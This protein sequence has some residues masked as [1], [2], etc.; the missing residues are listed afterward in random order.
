M[1]TSSS[2]ALQQLPS[3]SRPRLQSSQ[4]LNGAEDTASHSIHGAV[5]MRLPCL[6][7]WVLPMGHGFPHSQIQEK[8]IQGEDT[9]STQDE[10]QSVLPP[11]LR[12]EIPSFFPYAIGHTPTLM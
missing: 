2:R 3:S 7:T 1:A 11:N 4:D 9:T 6:L 12:S 10:S 5:G 8:M